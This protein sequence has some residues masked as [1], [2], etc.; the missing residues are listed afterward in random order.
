MNKYLAPVLFLEQWF[1]TEGPRF[2]V[3]QSANSSYHYV[4]YNNCKYYCFTTSVKIKVFD[5]VVVVV[6]HCTT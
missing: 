3:R 1:S 2:N 6:S 5:V 4:F